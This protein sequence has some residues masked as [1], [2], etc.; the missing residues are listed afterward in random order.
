MAVRSLKLLGGG[1]AVGGSEGHLAADDERA[2]FSRVKK[3][4]WSQKGYFFPRLPGGGPLLDSQL[5][6][7][8]FTEGINPYNITSYSQICPICH[9][10]WAAF[11]Q[12]DVTCELTSLR[13]PQ[14]THVSLVKLFLQNRRGRAAFF[15]FYL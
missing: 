2:H 13:P 11:F 12:S 3:G 4:T 7:I 14:K 6:M 15:F 1:G 8:S 5:K 9:I 10:P